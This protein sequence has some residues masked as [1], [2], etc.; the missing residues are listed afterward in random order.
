MKN[1]VP[2]NPI[3]ILVVLLAEH[4]YVLSLR[5]CPGVGNTA[6]RHRHP[7]TGE[8]DIRNMISLRFRLGQSLNQSFPQ[9]RRWTASV[10]CV[11]TR[12]INVQKGNVERPEKHANHD[13]PAASGNPKLQAS[14]NITPCCVTTMTLSILVQDNG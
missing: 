10:A 13:L 6:V 7:A 9:I 14:V 8:F 4:Q 5:N 12:K 3:L 2:V 1:C 11:C